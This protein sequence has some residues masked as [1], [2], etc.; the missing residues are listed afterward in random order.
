M[1]ENKV[2]NQVSRINEVEVSGMAPH[3]F[4]NGYAV[5]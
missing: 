5:N 3:G 2:K 4:G 1:N